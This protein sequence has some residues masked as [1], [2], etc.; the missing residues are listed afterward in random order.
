MIFSSMTDS[1][2]ADGSDGSADVQLFESVLVPKND[3]PNG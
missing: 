3:A 2:T 1:Y